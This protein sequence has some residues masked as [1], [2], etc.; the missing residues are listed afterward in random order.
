MRDP[1][2]RT[3]EEQLLL[4]LSLPEGPAPAGLARDDLDWDWL[5]REAAFHRTLPA[6]GER[7]RALDPRGDAPG[8]RVPAAARRQANEA[9]RA[10]AMWNILVGGTCRKMLRALERGGVRGA[11]LKGIAF[12]HTLYPTDATRTL[13]DLDLLVRPRDVDRA[14]AIIEGLGYRLATAPYDERYYRERHFHFRLVGRCGGGTLTIELHWSLTPP[15]HFA[16]LPTGEIMDRLA[17]MRIEGDEAWTLCPEDH[18]FHLCLQVDRF[19]LRLF[20]HVDA[21]LLIARTPGFDWDAFVARARR[22]GLR[23]TAASFLREL[24]LLYGTPIPE[25]VLRALPPDPSLEAAIAVPGRLRSDRELSAMWNQLIGYAMRERPE[26]RLRFLLRLPRLL[27]EDRVW[28]APVGPIRAAI[29]LLKA[30]AGIGLGVAGLAILRA[31]A[32]TP[33]ADAAAIR[34]L[35]ARLWGKALDATAAEHPVDPDHGQV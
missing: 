8:I 27:A 21:H 15:L 24:A 5:I 25:A 10:C 17:P 33:F 7:L 19:R 18:L 16:L 3:P 30:Y 13:G 4:D 12:S 23:R 11:L 32:P 34:T 31:A 35:R 26:V 1:S 14:R 9:Y 2:R 6:M 29:G 20:R 28:E 22:R